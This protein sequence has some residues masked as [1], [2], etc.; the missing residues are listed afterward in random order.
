MCAGWC[1]LWTCEAT[2]FSCM[3]YICLKSLWI[4]EWKCQTESC[5]CANFALNN[6]CWWCCYMPWDTVVIILTFTH[7]SSIGC[8]TSTCAGVVEQCSTIHTGWT[9]IE[10]LHA[11]HRV[12]QWYKYV[13]LKATVTTLD[14]WCICT[15][16]AGDRAGFLGMEG[17]D[18]INSI[19]IQ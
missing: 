17:K 5:K 16:T 7:S 12:L 8:W 3:Q 9:W 15:L 6:D 2:V 18:K 13:S 10:T 19:S 11:H 14:A 4:L 1:S